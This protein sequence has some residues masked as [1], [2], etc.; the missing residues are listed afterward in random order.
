MACCGGAS[1]VVITGGDGTVVTGSGTVS[2]PYVISGNLEVVLQAKDTTTVLLDLT[3]KGTGGDPFV[4]TATATV[5]VNDLV[6]VVD[7]V[8]ATDG[9]VLIFNGGVW[10]YA[11]PNA[12]P[13]GSVNVGAGI[14][15][16]GSIGAPI[17]VNISNTADTSL[18]GLYTYID[19]LG[20]LRAQKP[21]APVVSWNNVTDKPS[22]FAPDRPLTADS[23]VNGYTPDN[24]NVAGIHIFVGR[25][26]PTTAVNADIW[27]QTP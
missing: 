9:D 10:T 7:P 14:E 25:T 23:I 24:V 19:S 4:L 3:G 18:T 12:V 22:T 21:P 20:E 5:K 27:F 1:S 6:D 2:D 16:D 17:A 11:P 13:P 15:G 26:A 8:P